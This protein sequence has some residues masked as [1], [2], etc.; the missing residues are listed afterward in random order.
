M[1]FTSISRSMAMRSDPFSIAA[2]QPMHFA[3]PVEARSA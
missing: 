3:R 1:P 2:S